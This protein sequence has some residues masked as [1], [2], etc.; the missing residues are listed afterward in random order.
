VDDVSRI[1]RVRLNS[2][3]AL[4]QTTFTDVLRKELVSAGNVVE[5]ITEGTGFFVN[6]NEVNKNFVYLSP[7]N[8]SSQFPFLSA[9]AGMSPT[10]DWFTEWYLFRTF[11]EQANI[12][13]DS[14]LIRSYPYDAGTDSGQH[15]TD[16][17]H[18]TD[19]KQSI[20]R[21]TTANTVNGA[22]LDSAGDKIVYVAEWECVLQTCPIEE[23]NCQ[24]EDWPPA[25]GCDILRYPLC[26]TFCDPKVDTPCELCKHDQGDVD[27]VF[28]KDCCLAGRV[29]NAG[30]CTVEATASGVDSLSLTTAMA[31]A[32]MVFIAL[33]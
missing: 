33:R 4:S 13:W 32:I 12:F 26:S 11:K 8:V 14:F 20:T 31:V 7:V 2:Q 23:P 17:D 21:I 16:P 24:K 25:N 22:F 28:H 10:P 18:S 15:Y 29:P 5:E 3:C 30:A 19:P 1:V 9:I 27:L 6:K